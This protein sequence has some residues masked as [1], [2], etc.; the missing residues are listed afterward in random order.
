MD[1]ADGPF[2]LALNYMDAHDPYY[3][4]RAC[5]EPDG[6]AAALRCLDRSLAPIEFTG[7][8]IDA[9]TEMRAVATYLRLLSPRLHERDLLKTLV[10]RLLR[11][12]MAG[13]LLRRRL[14]RDPSLHWLQE[15]LR[16]V[17]GE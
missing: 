8:D 5:G 15:I 6:Y 10:D 14:R 13:A 4:E 17:D 12:P 7:I 16:A 3:V 1:D 9:E 11:V 2:F